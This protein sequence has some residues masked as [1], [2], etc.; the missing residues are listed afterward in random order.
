MGWIAWGKKLFLCHVVLVLRALKRRPD[1]NSSKRECAGCEESR[2]ILPFCSL[3]MIIVIGGGV[4]RMICSAVQSTLRSL[5]RS[6][7]VAELNQTVIDV[8]RTDSMMAEY[9]FFSTVGWAVWKKY[10]WREFLLILWYWMT[11]HGP[12]FWIDFLWAFCHITLWYCLLWE[13]FSVA[14]WNVAH[15]HSEQS[16]CWKHAY[17]ALKCCLGRQLNSIWNRAKSLFI[18]ITL[19]A[20]THRD[21]YRCAL[22]ASIF[23]RVFCSHPSDFCWRWAEWACKFIHWH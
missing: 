10:G 18:C 2:V 3:W 21:E 14:F 6:D 16:A 15:L 7:L 5:L 8:Q 11:I 19:K 20:R 9:T 4:V 23:Q 1:G 12:P 13:E 17:G 22:F